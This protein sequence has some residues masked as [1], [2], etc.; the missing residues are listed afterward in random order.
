MK[1]CFFCIRISAGPMDSSSDPFLRIM[2]RSKCGRILCRRWEAALSAEHRGTRRSNS[3]TATTSASSGIRMADQVREGTACLSLGQRYSRFLNA[4][5]SGTEN[6]CEDARASGAAGFLHD[7]LDVLF[8]R[9]FGNLERVRDFLVRLPF[10]Q[11]ADHLMLAGGEMEPLPRLL[12][13]TLFAL[14]NLL[15]EDEDP[16]QLGAP[17]IGKPEG[18]KEDGRIRGAHQAPDMHLFPVLRNGSDLEHRDDFGAQFGDSRREHARGHL[19]VLRPYNLP[20]QLPGL[21]IHM[22]QLHCGRQQQDSRANTLL[23]KCLDNVR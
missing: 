8:D 16:R 2:A 9:L 23:D 13:A 4:Y 11:I 5:R 3:T 18:P 17:A 20:A 10:D 1:P 15:H 19:P 7:V 22:H 14:G 6:P 12:G 21:W